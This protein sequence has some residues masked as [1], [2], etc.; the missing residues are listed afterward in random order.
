MK[1]VTH[2]K[3]THDIVFNISKSIINQNTLNIIIIYLA[4]LTKALSR[5]DAGSYYCEAYNGVGDPI[6]QII[7][8]DV[9][10]KY[11]LIELRNLQ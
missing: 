8:V 4:P 9:L 3:T 11:R 7:T 10:C 1:S 5:E 6:R 2:I